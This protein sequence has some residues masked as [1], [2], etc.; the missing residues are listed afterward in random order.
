M[1]IQETD[2]VA[3][4]LIE[5]DKVQIAF[6]LSDFNKGFKISCRTKKPYS[7]VRICER[8]GGGGH[9]NAAGCMLQG[10]DYF[11]ACDKLYAAAKSELGE[12]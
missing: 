11:D 12:F 3:S 5:I 4:A 1:D 7:A 8:F 10:T 2:G 6:V 9:F